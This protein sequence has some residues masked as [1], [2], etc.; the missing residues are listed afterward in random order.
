MLPAPGE[1]IYPH[2]GSPEI[3]SVTNSQGLKL[4]TYAWRVKDPKAAVVLIHGVQTHARFEFL[5]HLQPGEPDLP[6]PPAQSA[7][8]QTKGSADLPSTAQ[9][10]ADADNKKAATGCGR[11]FPRWC[12][13][14]GS[15]VQ[16][17]NDAGFS[18]YAGDL[19]SFGLSEGWAGRRCSV[20][21]LDHF[22]SDVICFAEYAANDIRNLAGESPVPPMFLVGISMG[23]FS[24]IRSLELM[25]KDNHWLVRAEGAAP[26][27]KR[28]RIAGCVALAPMLSVEKASSGA[29]NKAAAKVGGVLSRLTPHWGIATVPPARLPWVDVQK[30]EVISQQPAPCRHCL[31]CRIA[32]SL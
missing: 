27:D 4:T 6:S 28:P 8:P 26:E 5:R 32:D 3:G 13:Y 2:D 12:I 23:G 7:T 16:Q 10:A 9:P 30:D 1:N 24:V 14:E 20:E 11:Q 15:W 19:Q 18:V 29:F 25:G 31:S 22:G 21:R 17:L